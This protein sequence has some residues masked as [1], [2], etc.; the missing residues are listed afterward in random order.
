MCHKCPG[1]WVP[2]VG[3]GPDSRSMEGYVDV[4]PL[5]GIGNLTCPGAGPPSVI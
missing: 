3:E 5:D 4:S 2:R 1:I